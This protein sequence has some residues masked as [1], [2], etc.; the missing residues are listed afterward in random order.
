MDNIITTRVLFWSQHPCHLGGNLFL[1]DASASSSAW[2][3]EDCSGRCLER[4]A[5]EAF[6]PRASYIY[7]YR[8]KIV[9][10][11]IFTYIYIEREREIQ[12]ESLAK[13]SRP[14]F[15]GIR[16]QGLYCRESFLVLGRRIARYLWYSE[17]KGV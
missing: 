6:E 2:N 13:G 15:L 10:L 5:L 1:W 16:A 14:K 11:F 9:Y 17:T 3:E 12:Y 8:K 7:I 4:T